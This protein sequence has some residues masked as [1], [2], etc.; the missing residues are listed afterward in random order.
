MGKIV[1]IPVLPHVKKIILNHYKFTEPVKADLSNVIGLQLYALV[2]EKSRRRNGHNSY[3][4]ILKVDLCHEIEKREIRMGSLILINH[5]FDKHFKYLMFNW[6]QAQ[7]EAGISAYQ[8]VKNF[9]NFYQIDENEYSYE[10]GYRAWL[11]YKND[12]Y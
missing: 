9:L 8:A 2:K 11:R 6:I 3:R 7:Y 5:Y 4:D 1:H 12:E 10:S